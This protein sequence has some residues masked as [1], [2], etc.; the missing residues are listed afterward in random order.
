MHLWYLAQFF[1][2][3]EMLHT[4]VFR[5]SC[6]FW[7]NVENC[8]TAGQATDDNIIQRTRIARW[9]TKAT[10]TH[11]EYVKLT[12]FPRQ[13]SLQERAPLLLYT[14]IPCLIYIV[15]VICEE[16]K[17]TKKSEYFSEFVICKYMIHFGVLK[18]RPPVRYPQI[19][20]YWRR[21]WF[22]YVPK[23]TGTLDP[24]SQRFKPLQLSVCMVLWSC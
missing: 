16:F 19:H 4:E 18:I 24:L 2:E 12:D 9:V 23:G 8:C 1:L 10:K 11:S 14:Y 5:K 7:D 6:R 22:M 17:F 13:L 15:S 21:Q 20:K 3:W